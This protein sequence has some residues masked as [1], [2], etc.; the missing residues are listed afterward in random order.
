VAAEE[1]ELV[2]LES[3]L[4]GSLPQ[5]YRE[6]L[7]RSDGLVEMMPD[8]YI[9]LWSY[10]A[11]LT[12]H[13]SDAYGLDQSLPRLLLI[14]DDGGGELLGFDLRQSPLRLVLVNAISASWSEAAYQADSLSRLLADLRAGGSYSSVSDD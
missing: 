12:V 6:L 5:D 4:Q 7:K 1:A 10:E 14:G 3:K 2:E 9:R 8:A 11:V 13:A